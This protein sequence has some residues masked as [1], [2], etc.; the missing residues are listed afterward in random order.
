M[1]QTEAEGFGGG[2]T[3]RGK[4]SGKQPEAGASAERNSR[5]HVTLPADWRPAICLRRWQPSSLEETSPALRAGEVEVRS[6][7]GEGD[8]GGT[9]L[10]SFVQ[11]RTGRVPTRSPSPST[12]RVSTS[13]TL[14]EQYS[15]GEVSFRSRTSPSSF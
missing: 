12:F 15:A 5:R 6:T 14:R 10:A 11:R 9:L 13:P 4:S 2:G 7:E 3:A 8:R 1:K